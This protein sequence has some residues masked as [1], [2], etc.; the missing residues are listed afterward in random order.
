MPILNFP[1][2]R[3]FYTHTLTPQEIEVSYACN[4]DRVMWGLLGPLQS[5]MF[6]SPQHCQ[7]HPRS[8]GF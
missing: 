5:S 7:G 4:L 2:K 6:R 3:P 8:R 1:Y